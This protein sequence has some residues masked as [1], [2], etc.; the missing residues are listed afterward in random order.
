VKDWTPAA[1]AKLETYCNATGR[2]PMMTMLMLEEA[3]A[4]CAIEDP[5]C[6]AV[7]MEQLLDTLLENINPDT[8]SGPQ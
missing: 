6:Q 7:T 8:S 4:S 2:H 5:R 1:F 3:R